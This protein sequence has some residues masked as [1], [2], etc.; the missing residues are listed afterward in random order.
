MWCMGSSGALVWACMQMCEGI[1]VQG[2][3]LVSSPL[4]STLL[5]QHPILNPKLT[6]YPVYCCRDL[7]CGIQDAGTTDWPPRPPVAFMWSLELWI[8]FLTLYAEWGIPNTLTLIRLPRSR[9]LLYS[10]SIFTSVNFF[11]SVRLCDL[12][13]ANNPKFSEALITDKLSDYL[14]LP[15]NLR[16]TSNSKIYSFWVCHHRIDEITHHC[17]THGQLWFPSG[18]E[19]RY[20]TA[21]TDRPKLVGEH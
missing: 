19:Q 4:L 7:C 6:I 5:S 12:G 2:G 15:P 17:F 18:V 16:A 20:L 13:R 3:Q 14:M 1:I 8:I 21:P 11:T 10:K 9:A